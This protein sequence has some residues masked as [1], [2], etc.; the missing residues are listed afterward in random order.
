[1]IVKPV[2]RTL[3]SAGAASAIALSTAA[4]ASADN[5]RSVQDFGD[6]YASIICRELADEPVPHTIWRQVS[7]WMTQ[8]NLN[9]GQLQTG[10]GYAIANYCPTFNGVYLRYMQKAG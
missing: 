9:Y 6:A 2:V 5:Y 7:V 10:I 8:T 3:V 4:V 1:V